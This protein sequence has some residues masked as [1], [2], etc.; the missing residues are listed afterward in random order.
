LTFGP[1][2]VLRSAVAEGHAGSV[3]AG[4]NAACAAV[5]VLLRTAYETAAGY[6]G[7]SAKGRAPS[8]GYLSFDIGR[9]P[10]DAVDR[11]KGVG[12]FL[13]V[14]LSSVEREYPGLIDLHIES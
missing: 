13:V 2:G 6:E 9:F 1:D 10:P 14:G 5:T 3:P 7:V 4:Y 8:P 11:L 12:D